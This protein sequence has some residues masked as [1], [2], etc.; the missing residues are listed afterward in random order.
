MCRGDGSELRGLRGAS[1]RVP[2]RSPRPERRAF[3]KGG[4]FAAASAA[5]GASLVSPA[6]A[7][8]SAAAPAGPRRPRPPARQCRHGALG[9][10]LQ[11]AAPAGRDRL[12]RFRD[13]RDAHPP[14]KRRSRADDRGRWG[15]RERLPLDQGQEGREPPRRRAGRRQGRRWWRPRRAH[16]HRAGGDPRRRAGRRARGAH[17]RCCAAA[18]RQSAKYK[19]LA[20]GS[21]AAAWWGFQY[22][23]LI[24]GD[25]PARGRDDLRARRHRRT[26]L[27]AGDLQRS[28]GPTITDPE[29][30]R[31][32]E[33]IDYPG[34][35]VDHTRRRRRP[36]TC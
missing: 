20:F 22:K 23:D 33:T 32:I 3:L 26:R 28:A 7:Q 18:L 15:R 27:G 36:S 5:G 1:A 12:G 4:L 34:L 9:L 14:G 2:R 19:G 21:N 29:R 35:P 31:R 25:K 24:T 6:L 11:A 10:F 13:D 17:P 30:H 16:L 8:T